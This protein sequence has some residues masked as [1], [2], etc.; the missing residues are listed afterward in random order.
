MA[1]VYRQSREVQAK[2]QLTLPVP[3]IPVG[4]DTG[5]SAEG[6]WFGRLLRRLGL[7]LVGVA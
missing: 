2:V 6:D 1:K 4:V 3:Q 7:C 5:D